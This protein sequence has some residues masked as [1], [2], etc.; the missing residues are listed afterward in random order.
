MS[1]S[2]SDFGDKIT[3]VKDLD[4]ENRELYIHTS[5]IGNPYGTTFQQSFYINK[6]YK[7]LDQ[8]RDVRQ[9]T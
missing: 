2:A 7:D 4:Q 6:L 8:E 3:P 1:D 9:P 5:I